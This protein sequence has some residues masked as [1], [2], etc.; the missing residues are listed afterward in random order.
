VSLP[1]PLAG[2]LR[3]RLAETQARARLPSVSAAVARHGD[4]AFT[5]GVGDPAP[6]PDVQYRIGSIT[7]TFTAVLVLQLRDEGLLSLADPLERH[8]PGTPAGSATVRDLLGHLSGLT[9]EPPGDFWE[10]VPGRPGA[11]LLAGIGTEELVLP[12][13]RAWHYSNLAYGLLGLV[14]ERARR[15]A[16]AEVLR[17]R[18]LDPLGLR[19]TTYDPVAPYATGYR[20]H[21]YADELREEPLADTGA[22]APAGQLWST[23]TDLVR[24]GAFLAEP[25]AEVLAADTVEEMCEPV[26]IR[27]PRGWT[28]GYG[29]GLQLFRRGER[30][31][32]GH[33]G[34]MPGYVAGLAVARG[35][36]VAAATMANAWQG[37]DATL[38]AIELAAQVLEGDPQVTP[39]RPAKTPAALRELLGSW[40]YRGVELVLY[41][42]G[43][44][45]LLR[46]ARDVTGEQAAA[47]VPAGPDRYRGVDGGDRGELLRVRRDGAGTPVVLDLAT[48]LL[49]RQLDDPRGG[50]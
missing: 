2:D 5:A 8:L 18:V 12:A 44:R 29:L 36:A 32:A 42:R 1:E 50:P 49:T 6:D 28:S 19:R 41:V 17:A 39:W 11:E 9:R 34:S 24:W 21:P 47:F 22:M 4:V 30:V 16:Y 38:L 20:V 10:A 15:A 31:Y 26:A 27:D 40:W 46:T 14:V 25:T 33:G 45:L 3:R 35:E 7:K 23:P 43:G 48:W 13:R 37:V